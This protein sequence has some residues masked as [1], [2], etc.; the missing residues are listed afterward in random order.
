MPD[1]VREFRPRHRRVAVKEMAIVA[2]W[3]LAIAAVVS[4]L[5]LAVYAAF[6]FYGGVG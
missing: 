3:T 2:A 4:L 5:G 6:Y 1:T